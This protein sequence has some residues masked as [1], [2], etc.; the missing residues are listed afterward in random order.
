MSGFAKAGYIAGFAGGFGLATLIWGNP[1]IGLLFALNGW[2]GFP[3]TIRA[4]LREQSKAE[5]EDRA[6]LQ[7]EKGEAHE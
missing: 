7:Q 5:S 1:Y 6:A 4:L 3:L 2:I